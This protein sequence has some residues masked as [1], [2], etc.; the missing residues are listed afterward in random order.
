MTINKEFYK[1]QKHLLARMHH[2]R[3]EL[4]NSED[5]FF[6]HDNAPAHAAII[7]RQYLA[8][9]GVTCLSHQ[10]YSP[11]LSPPD[12]FLFPKLK[13]PMKGKCYTSSESIQEEVRRVLRSIQQEDFSRAFQ[14]LYKRSQSCITLNGDNLE[15]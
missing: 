15:V 2:A 7:V 1:V 14:R 13:M 12:Y 6:L 3:K 8:K 5:W 10:S 9:I 4:Y 11:D